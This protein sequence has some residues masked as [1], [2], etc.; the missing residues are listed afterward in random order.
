MLFRFIL[1]N[2]TNK[3]QKEKGLNKTF[4]IEES[5]GYWRP[6]CSNFSRTAPLMMFDVRASERYFIRIKKSI[7]FFLQER[8]ILH[9]LWWAILGHN[10]QHYHAAEDAVLH[11][12]L[13][14][15]LHGNLL[16]NSPHLLSAIRQWGEGKQILSFNCS[17]KYLFL[18]SGDP[19]YLHSDKFICVLPACGG[20]YTSN[21]TC[22]TSSR[23]I[24]NI[25]HD[26][27]FIKVT[28]LWGSLRS[29]YLTFFSICVT[30][31]VLNVHFRSPQ[32]HKMAPWV[33]RV[34]SGSVT[35]N[36]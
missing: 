29:H 18:V 3:I 12:Q 14:H 9:L 13:D 33:K 19:F 32:T 11:R 31:V 20:D 26:T 21:L 36:K 28:H 35:L 34:S 10:V 27:S 25:R 7:S 22:C 30:V 23:Q 1:L 2:T 4:N 15:P 17:F 16:L 8:K 6:N 24:S 5:F